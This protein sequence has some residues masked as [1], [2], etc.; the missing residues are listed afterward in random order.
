MRGAA[1]AIAGGISGC[2]PNPGPAG[3]NISTAQVNIQQLAQVVTQQQCEEWCWAACMSMLFDFYG[4][5]LSQPEIVLATYGKVVCLP[6]GSTTTIGRDLSRN[7]IDDRGILFGSRVISAYDV[8]N[9]INTF[10]NQT[11]VDALN[12]NNPLLYCNTHHAM[13]LYSV[14]YVPTP[15]GPNIQLVQVIDPWPFNPRSHALTASEM[16][17]ADLGGEM[18][19]LAEVHVS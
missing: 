15:T 5:P 3:S 12:S 17:R 2:I 9:G 4:H 11:I 13:I 6:A 10:T 18:T 16:V 14:S 8:F 19:F 7:Y 1:A